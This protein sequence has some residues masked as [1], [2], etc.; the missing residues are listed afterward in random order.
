MSKSIKAN[1]H[2]INIK[3]KTKVENFERR[4]RKRLE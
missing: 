2:K 4:N 3:S 1:I